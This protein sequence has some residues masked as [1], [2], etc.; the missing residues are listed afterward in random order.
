MQDRFMKCQYYNLDFKTFSW[1][2]SSEDEDV[3]MQCNAPV[4]ALWKKVND[5][6]VPSRD[7]SNQI[8]VGR[9]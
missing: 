4:P 9:E 6:P 3:E 7:V 1:I 5:F 2:F 8:L